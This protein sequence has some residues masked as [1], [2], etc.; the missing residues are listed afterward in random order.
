MLCVCVRVYFYLRFKVLF[1]CF[2]F[3]FLREGKSCWWFDSHPRI[4]RHTLMIGK[5]SRNFGCNKSAAPVA[6][7]FLLDFRIR[8]IFVF[9]RQSDCRWNHSMAYLMSNDFIFPTWLDTGENVNKINNRDGRRGKKYLDEIKWANTPHTHTHSVTTVVHI[10]LHRT[11][12][13]YLREIIIH[14]RMIFRSK[15]DE[16]RWE[17][18]TPAAF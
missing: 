3:C 13:F 12:S 2:L 16:N 10:A 17:K 15:R 11:T 7:H 5:R 9:T 18:K 6:P 4:Y 8:H 14:A 1:V